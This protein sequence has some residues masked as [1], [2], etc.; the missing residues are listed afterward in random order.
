MYIIVLHWDNGAYVWATME[1][2]VKELIDQYGTPD[3]I[4]VREEGHED[5]I[6]Y[7]MRD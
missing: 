5:G 7:M 2:E 3:Y 1:K 6:M 4:I